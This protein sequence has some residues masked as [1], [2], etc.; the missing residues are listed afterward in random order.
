VPWG[1]LLA[2][3]VALSGGCRRM[4]A[5]D[6]S[7]RFTPVDDG[8]EYARFRSPK[9]GQQPAFDG[10]AFRIDLGRVPMRVLPAGGPTKHRDVRRTTRALERVVAVNGSFFTPD[11]RAMGLVVDQGRLLSRRRAR[12]W[13]A[14][15]IKDGLARI[16]GGKEVDLK[17]KPDLVLQGQPRLV[18]AGKVSS[19]KPQ[20]AKR[21]VVCLSRA[22]EAPGYRSLTLVVTTEVDATHLGTFLARPLDEG[23][24]GCAEA[25]NLDG[26]PSTQLVA[27]LGAFHVDLDGSSVP[28]ALA[29]LP[30]LPLHA[31]PPVGEID[32]TDQDGD[33]LAH[34]ADAGT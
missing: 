5:E 24:M 21:T 14:L 19:L 34:E 3:L 8:V 25:L 17:S 33:G 9:E 16:V 10:H 23:G 26:G 28:N 30:G 2:T 13:G 29:A 32:G 6:A 12:A 11:D 27:R 1:L 22:G 15:V 31:P 7:V 20:S 4:P 18:R